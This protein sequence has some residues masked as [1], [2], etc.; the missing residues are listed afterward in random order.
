[1]Y[2]RLKEAKIAKKIFISRDSFNR[3]KNERKLP[4][5]DNIFKL[6][7][8]SKNT[9]LIKKALSLVDNEPGKNLGE[10]FKV[11]MKEKKKNS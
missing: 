5:I 4:N 1:M 11:Y 7:I 6:L 3:I 9:A 2:P 8:G 10:V